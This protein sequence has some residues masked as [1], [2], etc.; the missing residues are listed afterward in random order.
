MR[1]TYIVGVRDQLFTS[2]RV[3]PEPYTILL[4]PVT[5]VT[6]KSIPRLVIQAQ[7]VESERHVLRFYKTAFDLTLDVRSAPFITQEYRLTVIDF[8]T[9]VTPPMGSSGDSTL[10]VLLKEPEQP[11]FI[12]PVTS[13]SSVELSVYMA[14]LS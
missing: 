2:S 3:A 10:I 1:E 5:C 9:V 11:V 7:K 6:L 8:N 4:L 12:G 13:T 14:M